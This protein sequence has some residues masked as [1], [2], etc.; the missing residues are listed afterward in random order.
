[1]QNPTQRS[2]DEQDHDPPADHKRQDETLASAPTYLPIDKT[3]KELEAP[4]L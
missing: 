4:T 2:A 1:M 3:D